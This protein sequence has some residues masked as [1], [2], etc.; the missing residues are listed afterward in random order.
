MNTVDAIYSRNHLRE[1]VP[2]RRTRDTISL[3]ENLQKFKMEGKTGIISEFKRKSPS[4]F[5]LAKALEPLNYFR[6]SDLEVVSGLSILTEPDY[7]HG[8]YEDI[9]RVQELNLPILDKDFASSEMMVEN[10]FNSGADAILFILDFLGPEK[11]QALSRHA[12]SLGMEA[13]VEFHDTSLMKYLAPRE[14]VIYGYNRR[15]LR[16]LKM[17]PHEDEVLRSLKGME[18]DII[19]ESGI[20]GAYLRDHDVSRYMG[21]LIGTSILNGNFPRKATPE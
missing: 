19:L 6:K 13:L 5:S 16:T 3:H 15:N 1:K 21:L 18:I 9:S 14:G 8:S 12:A 7:F 17:E 11:V 4:G 10:A 2:F 20:D